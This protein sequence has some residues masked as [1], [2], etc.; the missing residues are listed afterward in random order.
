MVAVGLGR[1]SAGQNDLDRSEYVRSWSGMVRFGHV[2]VIIGWGW[3]GSVR[4]GLELVSN[5]A[6]YLDRRVS[7]KQLLTLCGLLNEI[8]VTH[9][10]NTL[11]Q[12]GNLCGNLGLP[13]V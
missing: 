13:T 1:V 4:V 11:D 7:S 2:S 3:L 9:H 12:P 5:Q 8:V 6:K 10:S